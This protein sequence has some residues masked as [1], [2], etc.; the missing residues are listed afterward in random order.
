MGMPAPQQGQG[1][2][3]LQQLLAGLSSSGNPQLAASVSRRSP[4]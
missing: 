2:S 1:G 3:A 4:A